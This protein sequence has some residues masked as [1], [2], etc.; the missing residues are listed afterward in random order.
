M[1]HRRLSG[2]ALALLAGCF[3]VITGCAS[4]TMRTPPE[5]VQA[6]EAY[7]GAATG[8]AAQYAPADLAQA[9]AAL[10][11]AEAWFR[12]HP[13]S[14]QARAQAYIAMRRAQRAEAE[15]GTKVAMKARD[16]ASQH[17][18]LA[19]EQ[20]LGR[21]RAAL[22][23]TRAQLALAESQLG[24]SSTRAQA[25]EELS[26]LERQGCTHD[27][28]QAKVIVLFEK[29]GSQFEPTCKAY[30]DGLAQAMRT[31]P[32]RRV[33]I[34]GHTDN[35]GDAATNQRLSEARA[36]SVRDYLVSQGV[37]PSR[38]TWTGRGSSESLTD[39]TTP[40]GRAVNR[41]VE[42]TTQPAAGVAEPMPKDE[43]PA[44]VRP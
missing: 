43:S 8:R 11:R 12:A 25:P 19:Q 6:R 18:L 28:S 44:P 4:P 33:R 20:A 30:L 17:G 36:E 1:A 22:K 26:A 23:S 37:D 35:T 31:Q 42:I 24:P 34:E 39:N 27:E 10:D 14:A 21:T 41:R 16:D 15:A 29:D 32:G 5:L 7:A 40:E 9:K 2:C 38:V 3:G 13:E